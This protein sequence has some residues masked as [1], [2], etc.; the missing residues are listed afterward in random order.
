MGPKVNA[1]RFFQHGKG[2]T[3]VVHSTRPSSNLWNC[4]VCRSGSW[5]R[6]VTSRM[7]SQYR[8]TNVTWV[9]SGA[10]T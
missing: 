10:S 3:Q 6:C 7:K 5:H 4:L 2:F 8:L 1:S 9:T